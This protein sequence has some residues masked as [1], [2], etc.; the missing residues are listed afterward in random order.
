MMNP[1][2]NF[3]ADGELVAAL[4]HHQK[5]K[6]PSQTTDKSSDIS[7][8]CGVEGFSDSGHFVRF[9]DSEAR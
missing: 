2:I 3:S 8:A 1:S 9:D 4:C 6:Q 5:V 7:P